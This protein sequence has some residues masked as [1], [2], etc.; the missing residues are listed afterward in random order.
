MELVQAH[1]PCLKE[2]FSLYYPDL[3]EL[4]HKLIRNPFI[5][6]VRL[7]PNNVQEEF[8]EFLNDSTV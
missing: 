1:I 5:V 6:D 8:I 7:I 3:S 2:E 4:D